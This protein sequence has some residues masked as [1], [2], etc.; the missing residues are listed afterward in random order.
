MKEEEERN[1]KTATTISLI[2]TLL[3]MLSFAPL[4][5]CAD[6][7]ES[8]SLPALE[9][10]GMNLIH[11]D[12]VGGAY[13]HL[14]SIRDDEDL[15]DMYDSFMAEP[16]DGELEDIGIDLSW[17]DYV[18][19]SSE[20]DTV[21]ILH[22]QIDIEKVRSSLSE[23]N[24]TQ[25]TCEGVEFW[26]GTYFAFGDAGV[27]F[28]SDAIVWGEE[29]VVRSVVRTI[30]DVDPSLYDI[31]EV[32]EV[33][34]KLPTWTPI[35]VMVTLDPL[36]DLEMPYADAVG[37]IIAKQDRDNLRAAMVAKFADADAAEQM[38]QLLESSLDARCE[39]S[40]VILEGT[41]PIDEFSW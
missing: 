23:L 30:M 18:V 33:F 34:D 26:N 21:G 8:L 39:G 10:Y 7:E 31:P 41:M 13:M 5:G 14:G 35:M 11:G 37:F 16:F 1:V 20:S 2:I 28:F 6:G 29:E 36:T 40:W 17:I 12:A 19:I 27:A 32:R 38:A 3:T 24:F 4:A 15:S 25:G 22:G 9:G